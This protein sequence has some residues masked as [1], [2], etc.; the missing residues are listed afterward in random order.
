MTDVFLR[1][2]NMSISAG[3]LALVVL[4]ARC[5]LA[6]RAPKR[7]FPILW[8]LVGIRLMLPFTRHICRA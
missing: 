2:L 3:I 6:K 1:V 8:G 4:L 5:L 7:L